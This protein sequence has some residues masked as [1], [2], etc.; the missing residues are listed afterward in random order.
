MSSRKRVVMAISVPPD[1]AEECKKIAKAKGETMSQFFSEM[2][3]LYKR[4]KMKDEFF[5]LQ[6]YGSK[7]R[8]GLR[9]TEKNIEK[10]IFEGR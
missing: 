3:S 7:K 1:T 10:L 5:E 9:I 6:R 2:F 8:R 4:E